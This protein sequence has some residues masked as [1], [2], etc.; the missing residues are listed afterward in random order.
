M[1]EAARRKYIVI[2]YTTIY[3][4][5]GDKFA[6]AATTMCI[7]KQAQFPDHRVVC[8]A[9]ESKE[10]FLEQIEHIK[11]VEGE[12]REFHFIGHSGVYGIMFGTTK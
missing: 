5:G 7:E 4:T 9:V 1:A 10:E 12:I 8:Q 6:R 2:L 3:R 11:T